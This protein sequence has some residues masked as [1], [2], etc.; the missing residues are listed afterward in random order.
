MFTDLTSDY[1]Y[2]E[3]FSDS[4]QHR[5]YRR[6]DMSDKFS[7]ASGY[8]VLNETSIRGDVP[9]DDPSALDLY[10]AA[11]SLRKRAF[12]TIVKHCVSTPFGYF[13]HDAGREDLENE[14]AEMHEEAES[15]NALVGDTFQCY[16]NL[17]FVRSDPE[18]TMLRRR[19][20]QFIAERLEAMKDRLLTMDPRKDKKALIYTQDQT[21]RLD[22]CLDGVYAKLVRK[23]IDEGLSHAH[24]IK[25]DPSRQQSLTFPALDGTIELLKRVAEQLAE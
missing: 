3:Y 5:L 13:I 2:G 18:D 7:L 21:R 9:R 8:F 19:L 1:K 23:A 10:R 15:Y 11:D 6:P 16:I 20:A 24:D 22:I 12:Y 25:V 17:L 14:M 4:E